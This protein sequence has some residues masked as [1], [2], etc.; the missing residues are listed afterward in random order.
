[1]SK[2]WIGNKKS[3]Y[4]TLGASNHAKHDR[5]LEDYYAT[6]PSVIKPLFERE[7]FNLEIW[8]CACGE[9]HLSEAMKEEKEVYSSD[10]VNRGYGDDFFDFLKCTQ[11]HDSWH[12]D[13]ITNPP[14]KFAREFIEKAIELVKVG[15]KVAMFLKLQFLEGQ[16]RKKFFGKYPPKIIYV[17]SKRQSCAMNGQFEKYRVSAV[18]YAWFVWEKGFNGDPIVRWI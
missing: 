15:S 6:H 13:I 17:F 3:T 18:A 16:G 8:E 10:I 9:G 11:E 5:Q 12:G 2:N 7:E 14:Y 4:V 1:M